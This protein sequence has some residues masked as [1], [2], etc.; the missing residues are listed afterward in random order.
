M[1][2]D[3]SKLTFDPAKHFTR[4]LQQ[5]GRVQL[6]ADWNEQSAILLHYI[7]TLASDLIGDH[8]GPKDEID[9]TKIIKRKKLGFDLI[10]DKKNLE[11]YSDAAL[12][13]NER[14]SLEAKLAAPDVQGPFVIGKGHYY[15][16]GL[17]LEVDDFYGFYKQP[18]YPWDSGEKLESGRH[19]IYLDVW[20]RHVTSFEDKTIREVALEGADTASRAKLVWQVKAIKVSDTAGD[21]GSLDKDLDFVGK[22]LLPKNRGWLKVQAKT[23]QTTY[24]PCTIAP[25]SSYRGLEDQLYRVEV[26]REDAEHPFKFKWSRDN[27]SIVTGAKLKGDTLKVDDPRGFSAGQWVE[28]TNEDQEKLGLSGVLVKIKSITDNEFTFSSNEKENPIPAI[29]FT[30]SMARRWDGAEIIIEES[31]W[32]KLADG[33]SIEFQP[34]NESEKIQYRTGDYWLIPARTATANVEWPSGVAKPPFGVEHQYA[35]LAL[36]DVKDK[37][38]SVKQDLRKVFAELAIPITKL[39]K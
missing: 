16:N 31:R 32:Q 38:S 19:L 18:D 13:D 22:E 35:P 24:E 14:E 36:I 37:N 17:L 28:I 6:D 5:Q 26:Y 9:D 33:I 12:P 21:A 34:A 15:V 11:T 25:Q 3:F 27:A 29:G 10:T 4:V 1:K 23:E 39:K 7:Q 20:E 30:P 2:G 8:G